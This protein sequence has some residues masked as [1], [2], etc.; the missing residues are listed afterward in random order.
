M[1]YKALSYELKELDEKKGIVGA[2]ANRYNNTDM[3]GDISVPGSF[4]KSVNENFKRIRVLKNHDQKI[5]LGVPKEIDTKDATGLFTVTQFNMKKEV[6]RDMFTD[7][8]LAHENGQNAELSIGFK[9]M[10]RDPLN[11]R[12][13]LEYKLWEYS[14]LTAWGVNPLATV[15]EIKSLKEKEGIIELITKAY[16][17]DYSDK[18]LLEIES[19]LKA[20]DT[21]P[22]DDTLVSKPLDTLKE[23]NRQFNL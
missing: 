3:V 13:I 20:L 17:L 15:Q 8:M 22:S 18:R 23:F 2:Y 12:R 16:D 11:R 5:S 10:K 21:K 7:V 1:E 19:I 14:F 9:V 4:T 6:S